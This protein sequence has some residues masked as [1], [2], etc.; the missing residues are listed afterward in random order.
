MFKET[1]LANN[2][3]GSNILGGLLGGSVESLSV[4]F[5]VRA[6]VL[7]AIAIYGASWIAYST[8][9][10]GTVVIPGPTVAVEK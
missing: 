3:L 4:F 10:H 2:A 6:M 5:G 9:H 7:I 1:N 8:R